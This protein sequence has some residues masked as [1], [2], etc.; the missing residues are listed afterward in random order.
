MILATIFLMLLGYGTYQFGLRHTQTRAD[1]NKYFPAFIVFGFLLQLTALFALNDLI[2]TLQP[3]GMTPIANL[4]ELAEI[5]EDERVLL[6]GQIGALPEG[7][8]VSTVADLA[9]PLQVS[10]EEFIVLTDEDTFA[11]QWPRNPG[12]ADGPRILEGG[13]AIVV[14]GE[15]APAPAD[16]VTALQI[17]AGGLDAYRDS[18]L[19][20]AIVPGLTLLISVITGLLVFAAPFIRRF[21]L[22]P[23]AADTD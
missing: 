1:V 21:R 10:G 20:F 9:F 12:N 15:P 14:L 2:I 5:P 16:A 6:V 18:L 8:V 22:P 17:F 23:A 11:I 7:A 13:A 4:A 3:R 19:R